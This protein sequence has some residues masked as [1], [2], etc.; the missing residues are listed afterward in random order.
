MLVSLPS[1]V[2]PDLVSDFVVFSVHA[3]LQAESCV[4]VVFC[5]RAGP[6]PTLSASI[7]TQHGILQNGLRGFN[8]EGCHLQASSKRLANSARGNLIASQTALSSSISIRLSPCSYL[9][10][11][12]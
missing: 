5:L 3:G 2:P 8:V 6:I 7:G 4:R 12:A 10:I 11:R 9:L 1:I